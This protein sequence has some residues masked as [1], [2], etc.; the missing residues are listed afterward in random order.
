MSVEF[1][2][3]LQP[4]ACIQPIYVYSPFIANSFSLNVCLKLYYGRP[5]YLYIEPWYQTRT[6]RRWVSYSTIY[7][8]ISYTFAFNDG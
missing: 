3:Y 8:A 5:S 2:F 6:I 7:N 1:V 4:E